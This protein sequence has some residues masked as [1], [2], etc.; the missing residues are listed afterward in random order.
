MAKE[1]K[2]LTKK[3]LKSKQRTIQHACRVGEFAVVPIPFAALMIAN[4]NEWFALPDTS[5]KIGLGASLTIALLVAAIVAV[6]VENK[7]KGIDLGYPL[8]ITKWIMATIIISV[9]EQVLHQISTIMWIA[10]SGLGAS[11]GLDITRKIYKKKADKTQS[12]I[13]DAEHQKGIEQARA[14]IESEEKKIKIKIKK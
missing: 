6:M 3:Q 12:E 14:E 10:L 13:D 9:V 7:D 8:L 1:K 2:E 4:R 5:W 11:Y